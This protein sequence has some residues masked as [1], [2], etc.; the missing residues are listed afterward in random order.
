MKGKDRINR[1]ISQDSPEKYNQQDV[2]REK[3]REIMGSWL[4]RLGRLGKP[5]I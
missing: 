2:E 3:E 1:S 4:M 5:Q